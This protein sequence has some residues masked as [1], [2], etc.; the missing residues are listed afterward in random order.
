MTQKKISAVQIDSIDLSTGV[1]GNLSTAHLN[2]ATGASSSTF[3]RGDGTWASPGGGAWGTITGTLS[4][5]TDL[6]TALGLLAPKVSPAL[7]GTITLATTTRIQGDWNTSTYA[8]RPAFQ[9]NSGTNTY[10][11]VL[12]NNAPSNTGTPA[13]ASFYAHSTNDPANSNVLHFTS[14]NSTTV[15]F[16]I[17]WGSIASGTSV[18]PTLPLKF[19]GFASGTVY[20]TINPSGPSAT[21]DLITKTYAD[22]HYGG[23][24]PSWLTAVQTDSGSGSTGNE[25]N[26]VDINPST[27]RD[28]N[29]QSIL[30]LNTVT[31]VADGPQIQLG[32]SRSLGGGSQASIEVL[33]Y[34]H[35]GGPASTQT[36]SLY[37]SVGNTGSTGYDTYLNMTPVPTTSGIQMKAGPTSGAVGTMTLEEYGFSVNARGYGFADPVTSDG[38]FGFNTQSDGSVNMNLWPG[39][40]TGGANMANFVVQSYPF[41]H[42]NTHWMEFYAG[43]TGSG[44]LS[45]ENCHIGV[46]RVGSGDL[47][48]IPLYI[49]NNGGS[50]MFTTGSL[51]TIGADASGDGLQ[52][53]TLGGDIYMSVKGTDFLVK[54]SGSQRLEITTSGEFKIGSAASAGT[55]GQ[56]LTS[57]GAS[58]EPAWSNPAPVYTLSTLP[59]AVAGHMITVSDA[60]SG[61]GALCYSDGST[62]KDAGTH[63][64]V[65]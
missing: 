29:I 65:V 10:F 18:D 53:G 27:G 49:S 31:S 38:I 16:Y 24:L 14:R 60:N 19:S 1:T 41:G 46:G 54:T 23:G 40:G 47:S 61:A 9:S 12:A 48:V 57:G 39:Y 6:N 3:W 25:T 22:A 17:G 35:T 7:S 59:T 4:A 33:D 43:S 26:E 11:T 51:M 13:R 5:Q 21:T 52:Y 45:P 56:V 50:T 20:A 44:G 37:V 34:A 36:S 62:W 64:T 63:A 32:A 15:P 42:P 58:A 55:A 2:S 30:N 28:G 8:N